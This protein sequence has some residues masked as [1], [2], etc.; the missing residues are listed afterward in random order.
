[1][2]G[3]GIKL[4]NLPEFRRVMR[5]YQKVSK[6]DN[7]TIVYTKAFYIARGAV[8]RT[9][10]VE[11]SKI[12]EEMA[13]PARIAKNDAPLAAILINAAIGGKGK[14]ADRVP[15]RLLAAWAAAG[16]G[17]W[18]KAMRKAVRA[19]TGARL[20]SRGFIAAGWLPAIKVFEPLAERKGRAPRQDRSV[21]QFGRPKGAGYAEGK[22]SLVPKAIIENFANPPHD[23][24]GALIKY[25]ERALQEAF[26]DE[27]LSM[28]AYIA[29]KKQESIDK[30]FR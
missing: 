11:R 4:T 17:L 27:M 24:H 2:P 12:Q 28:E 14:A 9:V 29:A 8:R 7:A 15:S 3:N 26:K 23:P 21:K 18:G 22:D 1:M 6:R 10:K 25:G 30:H 16:K 20:S 19:L 13:K 5:E